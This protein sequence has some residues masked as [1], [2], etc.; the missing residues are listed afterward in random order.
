MGMVFYPFVRVCEALAVAL[1]RR[2]A[3]AVFAALGD[4]ACMIDRRARRRIV[5][6]LEIA[7]G[8]RLSL[9]QRR[10]VRRRMFQDFARNL[11]DF[12]RL[13]RTTKNDLRQ[14]VYFEGLEHLDEAL[15]K[16]RGVLAVSAHFGSWEL[17]GAALVARGYEVHVLARDVFDRR[18]GERLQALRE[19]AGIAVHTG[20]GGLAGI[21]RALKRGSIV[22]VLLD[23]DTGGPAV[24]TE[25]FG[26]LAR[27][28]TTPFRIAR[29]IG[30]EIVPMLIRLEE[31][32]THRVRIHRALPNSGDTPDGVV[33]DLRGW[34]RILEREITAHP[35]QW[36]WFHQRW[37]RRPE[38]AGAGHFLA[39]TPSNEMLITR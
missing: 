14:L 35:S 2:A 17:L 1:P 21:V 20:Q 31:D 32:L 8:D 36:V 23:Q 12:L 38:A 34:H 24:F 13:P 22:G 18:V 11:V 37:K 10:D 28:P 39:P 5:G 29:R 16:G 6:H 33:Q 3:I 25:F 9:T 15:A 19:H 4:V 26:R 30:A 27:T 7:W